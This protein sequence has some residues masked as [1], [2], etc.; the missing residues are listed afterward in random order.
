MFGADDPLFMDDVAEPGAVDDGDVTDTEEAYTRRCEQ[1]AAERAAPAGVPAA[2]APDEALAGAVVPDRCV[3]V[4][5][6][7]RRCFRRCAG[8]N[9]AIRS[10]C[11]SRC[12]VCAHRLEGV[13]A[14]WIRKL[15]FL[16]VPYSR[17]AK[18]APG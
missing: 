16:K 7:A 18:T 17:R 14:V 1:Q 4:R 12:E 11:A 8:C 2:A 6:T 5:P 15:R 3:A 9:A 13:R 10:S